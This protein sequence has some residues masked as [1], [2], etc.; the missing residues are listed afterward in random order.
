PLRGLSPV[1]RG[2]A[3][4]DRR[5]AAPG[6]TRAARRPVG[7]R[8]AGAAVRA[9]PGTGGGGAS[10][11]EEGSGWSEGD[12]RRLTLPALR[13]G[14]LPLPRGE[15]GRARPAFAALRAPSPCGRGR[16][17]GLSRRR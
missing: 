2:G 17:L 4:P 12:A 9:E 5:C 3:I 1:R 14:P 13:A 11:A 15:R 10:L 7:R 16:G 8:G 6:R